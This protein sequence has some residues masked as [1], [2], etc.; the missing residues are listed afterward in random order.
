MGQAGADTDA[1][2]RGFGRAIRSDNTA[3]NRWRKRAKNKRWV[4]PDIAKILQDNGVKI[5]SAGESATDEYY[6]GL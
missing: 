5:D 4:A 1:G 3:S 6:E 2:P